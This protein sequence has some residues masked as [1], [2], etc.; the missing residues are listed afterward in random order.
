MSPDCGL[1]S[2][3]AVGVECRGGGGDGVEGGLG[4]PRHRCPHRRGPSV[5][6]AA[7]PPPPTAKSADAPRDNGQPLHTFRG[8]LDHLATLTRNTRDV[9]PRDAR[10]PRSGTED[11]DRTCSKQ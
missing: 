3:P 11:S 8:L 10:G 1:G 7:G 4:D 6:P 5:V 9:L 2:V